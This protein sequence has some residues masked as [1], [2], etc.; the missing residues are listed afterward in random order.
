M[1]Y[2]IVEVTDYDAKTKVFVEKFTS[3]GWVKVTEPSVHFHRYYEFPR[4][5]ASVAQAKEY[6]DRAI[7]TP[8][9]R[10]TEYP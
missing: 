2:R 9:T 4:Q 1:K 6:I 3:E 5:F 8:I 7:F 10:Y